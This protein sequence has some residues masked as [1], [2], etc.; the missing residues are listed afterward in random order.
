[1]WWKKNFW[2]LQPLPNSSGEKDLGSTDTVLRTCHRLPF[3]LAWGS[4]PTWDRDLPILGNF[5]AL[6][7]QNTWAP[8]LVWVIAEK[9]T[10]LS[11]WFSFLSPPIQ[12]PTNSHSALFNGISR[13]C[14][15]KTESKALGGKQVREGWAQQFWFLWVQPD[16]FGRMA[17]EE[18]EEIKDNVWSLVPGHSA[19]AREEVGPYW[20][21]FRQAPELPL[22][23][24]NLSISA[25]VSTETWLGYARHMNDSHLSQ[26]LTEDP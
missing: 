21:V 3:F 18:A 1:M 23:L 11:C 6:R 20:E 16:S 7:R 5:R 12:S 9:P 10:Y 4:S 26:L 13:I 2:C 15:W 17:G 22:A 14:L 24:P 19:P 25:S 8:Q